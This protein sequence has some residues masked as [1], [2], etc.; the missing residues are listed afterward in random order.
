MRTLKVVLLHQS[1]LEPFLKV[2]TDR[3]GGWPGGGG[4]NA[5]R[6]T[7]QQ[8][9][10]LHPPLP[11]SIGTVKQWL[12]LGLWE[13]R[14]L[15]TRTRIRASN[16]TIPLP[17]PDRPATPLF[18]SLTFRRE[19]DSFA[20]IDMRSK[21]HHLSLNS[22]FDLHS[23]RALQCCFRKQHSRMFCLLSKEAC[24]FAEQHRHIF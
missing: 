7:L 13:K 6:S 9:M 4:E 23:P 8:S 11:M 18:S 19:T 1:L 15:S 24:R 2:R 3:I 17:V 16:L 20:H 12:L 21:Q 14:V 10:M 5:A 22:R